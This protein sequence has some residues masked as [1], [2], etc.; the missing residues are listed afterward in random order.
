MQKSNRSIKERSSI[1]TS[2]REGGF[3][4]D[5]FDKKVYYLSEKSSKITSNVKNIGKGSSS[6]M[7]TKP[8]FS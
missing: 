4:E 8:S 5:F 1:H 7:A 3:L 6:F 2:L